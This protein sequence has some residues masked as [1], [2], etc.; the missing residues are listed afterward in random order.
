MG[1]MAVN[2]ANPAARHLLYADFVTQYWW[3]KSA[4]KPYKWT[5]RRRASRAVGRLYE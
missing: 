5:L 1:W 2:A 3:D 4:G